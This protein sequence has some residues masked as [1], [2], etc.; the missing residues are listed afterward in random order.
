MSEPILVPSAG[1]EQGSWSENR[2]ARHPDTTGVDPIHNSSGETM[3]TG[4]KKP[5]ISWSAKLRLG[6]RC[7]RGKE[8]Q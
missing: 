3:F 6:S 2:T 8:I 5:H 1:S 4:K 7:C